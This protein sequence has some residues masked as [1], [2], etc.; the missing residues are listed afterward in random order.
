LISPRRTTS[1]RELDCEP[2]A[3]VGGTHAPSALVGSKR[4]GEQDK[5]S[6]VMALVTTDWCGAVFKIPAAPC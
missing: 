4:G 1:K 3:C 6:T 2:L 5:L